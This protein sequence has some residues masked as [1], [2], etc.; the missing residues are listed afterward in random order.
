MTPVVT[1]VVTPVEKPSEAVLDE[2]QRKV[3]IVL[4]NGIMST[5]ELAQS[6]GISQPKN[7]RRRY[8]RL[9]LDMHFIEYTLPQKPNSKLQKYRLT[10]KGHVW[11]KDN[12]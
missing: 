2:I 8:L 11:L 4:G 6:V 10:E 1:P 9:L 7:M 12:E 3:L 5:S